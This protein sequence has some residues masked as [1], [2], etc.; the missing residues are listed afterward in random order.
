[1]RKEL[2]KDGLKV[3]TGALWHK[4]KKE[5]TLLPVQE[6]A[7][8]A[9]GFGHILGG[10]ESQYYGYLWSEVFSCDLFDQFEKQ[11]VMNQELGKKYRD[12]I[13]APG[14]S[15]DSDESLRLF[16]GRDPTDEA[17]LRLNGFL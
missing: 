15:K 4:I 10:Y 9:G 14:G 3:D 13:L 11:G 6:G 8:P 5:I 17:F 2:K 7:N 16:L 1:M 12:I